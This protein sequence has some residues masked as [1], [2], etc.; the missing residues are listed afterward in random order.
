MI[1][2]LHRFELAPVIGILR[3]VKEESLQGVAEA[4]LAG[5]LRFLEITLNTPDA[6][7][8]IKKATDQYSELTIGA[9]T[10][11]TAEEAKKAFDAGAQFI[12]APDFEED[13]AAFCV[14]NKLAYFPGALT[15]TEIQKAW[16]SGA[17]M[18]K[19][20]PASQMGPDYFK[21]V[22][23]PF[24]KVKLIAVG[25]VNPGNIK[26]YL[27]AG[28]DAVALG[29]SIYSVERMENARFQEIQKDIEEFMFEVKS[30]YSK[31]S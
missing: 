23:G 17:T 5:G 11:L 14:E 2:D 19:V 12:V 30:F 13:V 27:D 10:V 28:A 4:T 9:G 7:H 24:D 8:L 31:I 1:F 16:K 3:G 18:V 29:G 22:K 26:N 25:G 15:P 21:Q 6:F 20:F